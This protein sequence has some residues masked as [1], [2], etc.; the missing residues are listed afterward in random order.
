MLNPKFAV[1]FAAGCKT[2]S[3]PGSAITHQS[4]LNAILDE[5]Q[6]RF[7]PQPSPSPTEQSSPTPT[8]TLRLSISKSWPMLLESLTSMTRAHGIYNSARCAESN[9]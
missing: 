3:K 6:Q 2:V 7:A 8:P 5:D 9:Q 4:Q 1:P